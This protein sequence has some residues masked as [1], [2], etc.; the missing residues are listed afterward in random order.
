MSDANSILLFISGHDP[1]KI[2]V[3]KKMNKWFLMNC[4]YEFLKKNLNDI[5]GGIAALEHIK[6]K[7]SN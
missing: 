2:P 3:L 6:S 1:H 7:N 5:Y 4:Y